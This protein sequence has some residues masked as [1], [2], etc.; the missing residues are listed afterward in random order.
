MQKHIDDRDLVI[1]R[2]NSVGSLLVKEYEACR[3][4]E[5]TPAATS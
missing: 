4:V 3:G 5:P 2:K 1:D